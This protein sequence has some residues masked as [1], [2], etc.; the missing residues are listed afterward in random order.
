MSFPAS[1]KL[2]PLSMRTSYEVQDFDK[3]LGAFE[4]SGI[5]LTFE[6][7]IL[8]EIEVKADGKQN[9][10][11]LKQTLTEAYGEPNDFDTSG[12]SITYGWNANDIE[13]RFSQFYNTAYAK[14]TSKKVNAKLINDRENKV[15]EAAPEAA[16]QL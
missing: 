10:D 12:L 2:A 5:T 3:T 9:A 1:G 6:A 11:G 4:L 15:K 13:L 16:K 8:K 14:F 7:G